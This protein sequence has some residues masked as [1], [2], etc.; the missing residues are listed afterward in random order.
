MPRWDFKC[1]RC[2]TVCTFTFRNHDESGAVPTYCPNPHCGPGLSQM[3]R[4]PSAPNFALKGAGFHR[5][6]YPHS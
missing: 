2:S 6:D 1:E 5:N 4:L 3:T